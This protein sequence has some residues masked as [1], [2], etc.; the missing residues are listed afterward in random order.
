MGRP[1]RLA[2]HVPNI[3]AVKNS[4]L[5]SALSALS[6]TV[7]HRGPLSAKSWRAMAN[8]TQCALPSIFL[9]HKSLTS[10]VAF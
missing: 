3:R 8:T 9:K 6:G 10:T 2:N 4:E 5:A 7:A 1:W